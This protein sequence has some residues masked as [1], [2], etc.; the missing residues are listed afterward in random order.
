MKLEGHNNM[1]QKEKEDIKAAKNKYPGKELW[2]IDVREFVMD[3][4]FGGKDGWKERVSELGKKRWQKTRDALK[5]D[6]KTYYSDENRN[7]LIKI[8]MPIPNRTV[9]AMAFF[10]FLS[11]LAPK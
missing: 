9:P 4:I 3:S 2:Q 5:K 7:I 11:F 1:N 6:I 8:A 10:I